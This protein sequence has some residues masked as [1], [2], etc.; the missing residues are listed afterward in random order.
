MQ[1]EEKILAEIIAKLLKEIRNDTRK[2][3]NLFCNEYSIPTTTLNDIENAK[4]SAK[5]FSIIKI[6]TAYNVDI[7]EFFQ[8]LKE[9]L[10]K[11]FLKPE[12]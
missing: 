11:D 2:S 4:V 9:N 1:D 10:P 8:K 5:V 3:L 7:V 6:L 12:E